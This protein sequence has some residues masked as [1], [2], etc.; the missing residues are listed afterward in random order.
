MEAHKTTFQRVIDGSKQ[1]IIPVFQRDYAWG[2]PNWHRLWSDISLAGANSKKDGHF[3]GCIVHVSASTFASMPT[4][5]VIDGQQRLTTLVILCAALR[6]HIKENPLQSDGAIPPVDIL[7]QTFVANNRHEGKQ[8]YKVLL[9]RSDDEA[10]RAVVDGK[11]LDNLEGTTSTLIAECYRYFRRMLNSP[12]TDIDLVYRGMSQLQLAE[13]TLDRNSDDPQGVFE[14]L[15][16]TGVPLTP[17][18]L[19]RNY[20]LMGLE[21]S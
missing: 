7:E 11:S 9:R 16:S 12:E 15:N 1:F 19:I 6:D 20:L 17:G 4:N 18:D 3:V 13:I 2:M 14:S 10:L 5:L 8:R 21:V